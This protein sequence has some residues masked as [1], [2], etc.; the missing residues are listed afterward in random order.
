MIKLG[1]VHLFSDILGNDSWDHLTTQVAVI[2]LAFVVDLSI[3]PRNE[4]VELY[5]IEEDAVVHVFV[6]VH[7][8][9][10]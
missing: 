3:I 1:H 8:V 10:R 7:D 5:R 4:L 9:R 6:M 2:V